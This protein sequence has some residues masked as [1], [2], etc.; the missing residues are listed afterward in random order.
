MDL[1]LQGKR[2]VVTGASDGI[3][4]A[5][6]EL[7]AEEGATVALV[8]RRREM[9]EARCA[10]ISN[11]HSVSCFAVVADLSSLEGCEAAMAESL[12]RMGGL[13]ILVNN[14]GSSMFAGFEELPDE[15]WIPDIE[16]KLMSYVRMSRLALPAFRDAGGGRIVNVAGNSGKQPLPYHMSG[17]AANAAVL[18]LTTSL[19]LQVARDGVH[20]IAVSPG[21][22][23]TARF[24]KQIKKVSEDEEISEQEARRRFDE[25]MPIGRVPTAEEVAATIVYLASPRAAAITGTSLTIDG[26]ITRGI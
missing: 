10:E 6:A 19:A 11:K 2:A 16:L 3:G 9:L 12:E 13:E 8:A 25:E 23:V 20:V 5:V 1:K 21:P 26:G 18:N 7:L 15:R 24:N 17:A 4:L 22:V 14:V